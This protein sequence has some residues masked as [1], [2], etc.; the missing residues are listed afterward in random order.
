[1]PGTCVVTAVFLTSSWLIRLIAG[2]IITQLTDSSLAQP[3]ASLLLDNVSYM[4]GLYLKTIS[5]NGHREH[6]T[7]TKEGGIL[8]HLQISQQVPIFPF[9]GSLP[10][11]TI[12]TLIPRFW[13]VSKLLQSVLPS[14][15]WAPK[16][17]CC[18]PSED[19]TGH[20]YKTL[21]SKETLPTNNCGHDETKPT[22]SNHN[23][24]TR[25]LPCGHHHIVEDPI[26]WLNTVVSTSFSR[27]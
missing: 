7:L 10:K 3:V 20:V 23:L 4:Q 17:K 21:Q 13:Q 11:S 1:M 26:H 16:E 2:S 5:P 6:L 15:T 25:E 8:Q 12:S 19:L 24:N 9:A 14:E 27:I 22:Y 18:Q